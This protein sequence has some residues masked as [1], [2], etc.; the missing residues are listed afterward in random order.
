VIL[1]LM[2]DQEDEILPTL[3]IYRS[4]DETSVSCSSSLTIQ[5]RDDA[6]RLQ[7]VLEISDTIVN[8]VGAYN[9]ITS[10]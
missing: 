4:R 5:P 2:M 8:V 10:A 3:Y 1:F 9:S 6:S 7:L